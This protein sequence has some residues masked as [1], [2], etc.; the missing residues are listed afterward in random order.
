MS[1]TGADTHYNFPPE[2]VNPDVKETADYGLQY[3]KAMYNCGTRYGSRYYNGGTDA[4]EFD[5]L[6][7]LAQGRQSLDGLK[8]LFGFS[9]LPGQRDF[10]EGLAY[11][12][13]NVLNLAPKY[14]NRAVDKMQKFNYDIGLQAID[15]VSINEKKD[16]AAVLDAFYRQRKW[17]NDMGYDPRVLFPEIDVDSLPIHPDEMLFDIATNPKLKKEI[18]GELLM[19]FIH[20]INN[21]QQK[22]R[23]VDWDMVVYGRG[24][25]HCYADANGYPRED[26]INPKHWLGSYVE[27]DDFE[28]QEYAGFYDFISVN[29]FIK[30]T[31]DQLTQD[32]Q[33]KIVDAHC[34][35][36]TTHSFGDYRRNE[37]YDGL[38]YI[39]VMRF[40]FRSE[41]NRRFVEKKTEFGRSILIEK[42]HN[43]KPPRNVATKFEM[44][45]YRMISNSY[46]SIYGGTWVIDSDCVYN[47]KRQ[48]Y[49][50]QNL[51][52]AT[53]PIKTFATNF[54][55]GRTVSFLAQMVE[56]LKMINIAWNK[57]KQILAEERMGVM[58]IDF[59]QI[60]DVAMGSGGQKWTPLEVMKFFFK[61]RILIKRGKVNQH[62]QK[63]GNA[64]D[65]NVGGIQLADYM[66]SFTMGIQLLE[67]MTA[68][69]VIEQAQQPDRLAVK[70]A[71]LSQQTSDIDMGYLYNG[72]EYLYQRTSHQLLLI[73]QG[74]L[75]DGKVLEGF[76]PALGKV[77]LGYYRA[78]DDLAY[79]EYGM[80]LTRQP[81][82]EEWAEFYMDVSLALKEGRLGVSDS[83]FLREIDNLKQ[84]RQIMMIRE[85][86]FERKT[87]E[88]QQQV[89][90][91]QMQMNAASADQA[92]QIKIAEMREQG[93]ID[94]ELLALEGEIKRSLQNEKEQWTSL[95][96][97]HEYQ[98]K[99][100]I[101]RNTSDRELIKKGI[102][103]IPLK[104]KNMI[105]AQQVDVA[106]EKVAVEKEK[107][108][109]MKKRPAPA[110]K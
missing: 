48:N 18:A 2:F 94:A 43:Y 71:M 58:E 96:K 65:M 85:Q 35:Q 53:L 6:T 107:V 29:Q 46:T 95:N 110:K 56:P 10:T 47:Y 20:A 33:M 109:V 98:K 68:T 41:D 40:Y 51:V 87:Q 11:I 79:C 59:N 64:I 19:K 67:Q 84:A 44:G 62:D 77:N 8:N 80:Y 32:Q 105:D 3:A 102:E 83:A 100:Q 49:P 52:N 82:P 16:Y 12:D 31:S 74:S 108:E 97:R 36:N 73:A 30:E 78:S 28:Q 5:E 99:E 104:V 13:L 81:G 75:Q 91:Q 50:R 101:A 15:I 39:P 9:S 72:H 25:I 21:F 93:R 92:H 54:K 55:E 76:I 34:N 1:L 37:S 23:E 106:R 7:E 86:I 17:V 57:I 14:I 89:V 103:N 42:A 27:N 61:K 66:N 70:N 88:M 60:E 63:I 45:E 24:H 90:E 69:S 4:A 26:R 22:Q 38:G